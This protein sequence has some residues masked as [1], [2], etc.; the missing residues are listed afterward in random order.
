MPLAQGS[1]GPV[2][3]QDGVIAPGGIRQG[4]LGDGII[5]ELHGRF[6]EQ[7]FRG[8]VYSAGCNV[9]ALSANTITTTAPTTPI[10]GAYNPP[11]ST[12]NLVMLQL[13]LQTLV[14]TFTTPVGPGAFV[15]GA[16]TGNTAV[17]TG[18]APFNR[19]TLQSTGSQAKAFNGGV[20]LTG[21]T[22][23]LS[24]FEGLE[25]PA[26]PGQTFGTIATTALTSAFAGVVNFDGCIIVPPG[27]VLAVL[28][29]TS[30]TTVS[31]AGRLIWEEV[32]A[33]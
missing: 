13:A 21:L 5:S 26:L 18:A 7:V 24:I 12:V 29:T 27:G 8:N 10:L 20:A 15:L 33:A 6:Y 22:N 9:T 1:V 23:N 28:N 4:R 17:S 2:I 32:P 14:N 25:I 31:V 11:T 19:K 3:V 30:S 16:S